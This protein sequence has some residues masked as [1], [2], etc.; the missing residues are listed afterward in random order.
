M[1]QVVVKNRACCCMQII[2]HRHHITF[3][4]SKVFATLHSLFKRQHGRFLLESY[5]LVLEEKPSCSGALRCQQHVVL[6]HLHQFLHD[7]VDTHQQVRDTIRTITERIL[8][9]PKQIMISHFSDSVKR[10][11]HIA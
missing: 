4:H 6:D 11:R 8:N 3:T 10:K 5:Q 2:Q 1:I 9:G 7:A